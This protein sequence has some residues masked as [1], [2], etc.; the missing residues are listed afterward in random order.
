MS[1]EANENRSQSQ[2]SSAVGCGMAASRYV[3]LFDHLPP[4]L[5]LYEGL[6][7]LCRS[8]EQRN[9]VRRAGLGRNRGRSGGAEPRSVEPDATARFWHASG[10][11]SAA[12]TATCRR[13]GEERS[14]GIMSQAELFVAAGYTRSYCDLHPD[15]GAQSGHR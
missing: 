13:N 3:V 6:L 8:I 2:R 10:I 7:S 9:R 12:P 15:G 11:L 4:W 14:L 5:G 1:A